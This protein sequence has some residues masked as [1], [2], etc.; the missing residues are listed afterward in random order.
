MDDAQQ[1]KVR[2]RLST[3]IADYSANAG[4]NVSAREQRRVIGTG[5]SSG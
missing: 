2:R 4:A 5:Q 3:D 1:Q